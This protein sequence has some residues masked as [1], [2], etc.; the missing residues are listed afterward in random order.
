MR[1]VQIEPPDA[2]PFTAEEIRAR[3]NLA[4]GVIA[5]EILE[6]Y[7]ASARA[8]IDGVDGWLGR[9]IMTQ[10]WQLL[11]PGFP[12]AGGCDYGRIYIPLPPLQDVT[13]ISYI[14]GAGATVTLTNSD[15]EIRQGAR[16]FIEPAFGKS[17]PSARIG[18][19]SVMITFIAGYGDAGDDVPAPIR[20]AIALEVNRLRSLTGRDQ[21]V[22]SDSVVGLGSKT[23]AAGRDAGADIL[24]T[25]AQQLLGPYRVLA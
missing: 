3:L 25:A 15:F 22:I 14:D 17:W 13:E 23:Y 19:D 11:L 8:S 16:P 12:Y 18:S 24:S 20:S 7:I 6:A 21:S 1:L 4:S 2:E 5:D 9:C 10:T